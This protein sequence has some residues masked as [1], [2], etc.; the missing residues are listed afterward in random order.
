MA[1]YMTT[2]EVARYLRLN[3]KKVYTLVAQ[4]QLPAA[5]LS[6]KWLFAKAL[7]DQWVERNTVYPASGLIEAM[8]ED[9]LVIQGSDDYLLSQVI[10]RYQ[11]DVAI[12]VPVA[13]V[14][15]LAGLAAI[16]TGKAHLAGCHV[17]L[18]QIKRITGSRGCYL[19]D[20]FERHQGI[21][22]DRDRHPEIGG[23]LD[24]ADG[25]LRFAARQAQS[26]THRL[27][28]DLFNVSGA[29]MDALNL[30]GPFSSHM[31]VALAIRSGKADAGVGIRLAADLCGLDFLQLCTE[32]FK[33]AVPVAFASH[34]QIAQFLEYLLKE[35]KSIASSRPVG[36]GFESLG[37]MQAVG[38]C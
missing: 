32:S 22:Y 38:T 34:S 2:R 5:R 7:I 6:G 16:A 13:K 30:V 31:E 9:M 33:L 18:D 15:S 3:E 1:E 26:G 14:G 36:Y 35:L 29:T 27:V 37:R 28:A 11:T 8:L 19:V 25:K 24:F 10:Q 4:G 21:L 23:L 17:N 12:P 20:L